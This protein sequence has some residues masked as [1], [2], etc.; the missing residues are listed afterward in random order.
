[1]APYLLSCILFRIVLRSKYF[2]NIPA[3]D[4]REIH[5]NL[6]IYQYML[7]KALSYFWE[8]EK[9]SENLNFINCNIN[10]PY[11]LWEGGKYTCNLY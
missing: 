4:S 10:P 3:T 5:F 8:E 7:A 6:V 11:L 2:K 9:G 1:M